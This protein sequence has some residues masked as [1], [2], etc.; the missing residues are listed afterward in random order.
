MFY[1]KLSFDLF[2]CYGATALI[3]YVNDMFVQRNISVNHFAV[4]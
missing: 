1:A 4:Y 2:V 3:S